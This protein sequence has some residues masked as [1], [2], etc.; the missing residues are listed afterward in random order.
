MEGF[1]LIGVPVQQAAGA[2]D[3]LLHYRESCRRGR[4]GAVNGMERDQAVW[5][6]SGGATTRAQRGGLSGNLWQR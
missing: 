5:R 4:S 6:R 3:L 2:L 1:H